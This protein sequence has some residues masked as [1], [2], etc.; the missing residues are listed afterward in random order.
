MYTFKWYIVWVTYQEGI[1]WLRSRCTMQNV[2]LIKNTLMKNTY[3]IFISHSSLNEWHYFVFFYLYFNVINTL[4]FSHWHVTLLGLVT[5]V[6]SGIYYAHTCKSL[7]ACANIF[8]AN[9]QLCYYCTQQMGLCLVS[10][11]WV[12]LHW[13][14]AEAMWFEAITLCFI[15]IFNI[16]MLRIRK[17]MKQMRKGYSQPVIKCL[18]MKYYS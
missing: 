17:H 4:F 14:G 1:H 16:H 18:Y 9:I 3:V 6:L 11:F 10:F 8:N 12:L 2:G 5:Q 15:F 13:L 7:T